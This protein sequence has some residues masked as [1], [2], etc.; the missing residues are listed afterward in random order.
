MERMVK[1]WVRWRLKTWLKDSAK[2]VCRGPDK[3]AMDF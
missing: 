3:R 1:G 2:R